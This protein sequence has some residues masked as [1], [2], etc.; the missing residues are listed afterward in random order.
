MVD[1]LKQIQWLWYFLLGLAVGS[2]LNVLVYRLPHLGEEGISLFW[3]PSF[4]PACGKRIPLHD[5]IPLISYLNLRGKCRTCGARIPW[6]YPFLEALTA[7]FFLAVYFSFPSYNHFQRGY[8]LIFISLLIV[9]AWI[10]AE[11]HYVYTSLTYA[12]IFVGVVGRLLFPS[13]W[14]QVLDALL[15]SLT[16]VLPIL[17]LM[18]GGR[19]LLIFSRW[20]LN[21]FKFFWGGK[22]ILSKDI[23]KEVM[24]AGD[25]FIALMSGAFLGW[26]LS[27]IAL[28]LSIL[29]G[30]LITIGFYSLSSI[31]GKKQGYIPYK[32]IPF[33]PYLA[34]GS[35][36][37]LFFGS[38]LLAWYLYLLFPAHG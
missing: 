2:F 21:L 7:F 20:V 5:N 19:S 18:Y 11:T 38:S 10:D 30:A 27:L 25:V 37:S 17:L 24:G 4:C 33:G 8:D 1:P 35:I 23:P 15:G 31:M 32:E 12:G 26:K 13:P 14:F 16:F 29:S 22:E 3:P 34:L 36:L 6:R 28:L 9:I